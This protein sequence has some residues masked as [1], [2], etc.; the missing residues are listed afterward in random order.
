MGLPG[1]GG[2]TAPS[3][4]LLPLPR[5]RP[6]QSPHLSPLGP[7][8]PGKERPRTEGP[9]SRRDRPPGGLGSDKGAAAPSH[10]HLGALQSWPHLQKRRLRPGCGAAPACSEE[11][12]CPAPSSASYPLRPQG[13]LPGKGLMSRNKVLSNFKLRMGL[14]AVA[15][16][17]PLQE[18]SR[19][20][21]PPRG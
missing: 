7:G 5:H 12:L 13:L 15:T 14:L 11:P 18:Q 4:S 9:C 3:F 21:P 17:V 16:W 2:W 10:G 19:E 6:H 1:V 20:A 8:E